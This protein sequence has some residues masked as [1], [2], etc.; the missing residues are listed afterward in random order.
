MMATTYPLPACPYSVWAVVLVADE[1]EKREWGEPPRIMD[2]EAAVLL[3][4]LI[5]KSVDQNPRLANTNYMSLHGG[6]DSIWVHW[7]VQA[8]IDFWVKQSTDRAAAEHKHPANSKT[9]GLLQQFLST[10]DVPDRLGTHTSVPIGLRDIA[11]ILKQ[12]S[13][14]DSMDLY[15]HWRLYP[16]LAAALGY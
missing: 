12:N 5:E 6:A 14:W 11:G 4:L 13:R 10:G 9:A 8:E 15:I 3:D 2:A 7:I 1:L 16:I